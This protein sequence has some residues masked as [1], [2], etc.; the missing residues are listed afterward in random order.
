MLAIAAIIGLFLFL[1][2]QCAGRL[3]NLAFDGVIERKVIAPS[4]SRYS[5]RSS[6]I[7][8]IRDETGRLIPFRVTPAMYERAIVG[9]PVRKKAGEQWPT[10]GTKASSN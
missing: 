9:M 8:M 5:P 2:A 3:Q 6:Y 10:L 7:L 4:Q 1:P